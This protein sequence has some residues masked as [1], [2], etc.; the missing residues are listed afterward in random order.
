MEDF[1]AM[2]AVCTDYDTGKTQYFVVD[3]LCWQEYQ[4][5]LANAPNTKRP[6]QKNYGNI[7]V[8]AIEGVGTYELWTAMHKGIDVRR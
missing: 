6:T 7:M 3:E 8:E 4:R 1:E 2:L 5:K